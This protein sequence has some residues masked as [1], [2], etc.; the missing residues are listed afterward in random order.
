MKH[1]YG[2]KLDRTVA[3]IVI[4]MIGL[5]PYRLSADTLVVNQAHV[6]AADRNPGTE[7]APFRTINGAAQV[8]QPGDTVLVHAGIYRE[9]VAPA[10]GGRESQPIVYTVARGES[11]VI[12]GSEVWQPDW[13]RLVADQPVFEG[14]LDEALFRNERIHPYRTRLQGMPATKQLTLGQVFVDGQMLTEVDTETELLATEATWMVSKGG[15]ALIIHFAP[16]PPPSQRVVEITVRERIFAPRLRNLGYIHVCGF[17]MEHCA[18][19]FPEEFW[20]SDSPQAGALGCRA[21]HH[22]LIEN[23]TV[24]FARSIGIDCGYEGKR[25]LEGSQPTPQNTG[26]HLLRNNTVTDNGCCGI[27]GMLSTE[28]HIVG[29]V[30]QRNNLNHHLAPEMGGIKVH[31]FVDGVIDGNLVTDNEAYGIWLDNVDRNARVTRNLVVANRGAGIFIELSEGPV[32]VDNNVVANTRAGLE[33]RL[34]RGDG[35]YSVDASGINV[36]HNLVFGNEG[37]GS[38]HR[39]ATQRNHAGVSRIRVLNNIFIDNRSGR[40]NLPLPGVDARDNLADHNLFGPGGDFVLNRTGGSQAEDLRK[41]QESTGHNLKDWNN[42]GLRLQL[43][44]WQSSVRYGARSL[45]I[46]R[47][48]ADLSN[49]F[50]LTLDLG[51]AGQQRSSHPAAE[52]DRDFFL[53]A[54]PPNQAL[55]GPFQNLVSGENRFK[56]WPPAN[57]AR[58]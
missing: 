47:A 11:V 51:D 12:K 48:K 40:I 3:A 10:R 28:T 30:I 24:R 7:Q 20:K 36:A 35:I 14:R 55:V 29:N 50:L 21:G 39:K 42:R 33:P 41:L 56:L 34:P 22:W 15:S 4:G 2:L 23:N 57:R 18:N 19:Q 26:F 45:E 25:D 5:S 54:I 43:S 58:E 53:N 9:R 27:A 49:D 37:F 46:R 6:D 38:F 8:A 31:Y 52:L 32:S 13:N 17:T 44:E 1:R 16:G